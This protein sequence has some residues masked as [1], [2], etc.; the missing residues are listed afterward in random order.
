MGSKKHVEVNNQ[1]DPSIHEEMTV[2]DNGQDHV[3]TIDDNGAENVGATENFGSLSNLMRNIDRKYNRMVNSETVSNGL[4]IVKMNE[5]SYNLDQL[6]T[7]A[8]TNHETNGSR[9]N[10]IN[11]D[12]AQ[13][14][15][16]AL[17]AIAEEDALNTGENQKSNTATVSGTVT[18]VVDGNMDSQSESNAN[19]WADIDEDEADLLNNDDP[20]LNAPAKEIDVS[21]NVEANKKFI[22]EME[23]LHKT[24]CSS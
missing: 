12:M 24:H 16:S 2:T 3:I 6:Q 22:D 18:D 5:A 23:K 11:I 13:N 7:N 8:G 15:F 21:N 9:H 4:N 19:E 20:N 10:I 17:E 1:P 14:K